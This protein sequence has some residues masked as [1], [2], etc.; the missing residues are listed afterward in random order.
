VLPDVDIDAVTPLIFWSAFR[1]AGQ[2]CIASKRVYAH[3]H[4]DDRL[5]DA[6]VAFGR[7]VHV[8]SGLDQ[9]VQMGPLTHAAA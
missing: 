3:A 9:S 5:R 1:N 8:G 6:L 2:V 7:T 4:I